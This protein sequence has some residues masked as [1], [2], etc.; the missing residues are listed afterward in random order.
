MF[1]HFDYELINSSNIDSLCSTYG[2]AAKDLKENIMRAMQ[3]NPKI[4]VK[5]QLNLLLEDAI[6]DLKLKVK[7]QKN[8]HLKLT[9]LK[10]C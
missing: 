1:K 3:A 7:H 8:L 4:S 5:E 10:S 9:L 2:I 6:E